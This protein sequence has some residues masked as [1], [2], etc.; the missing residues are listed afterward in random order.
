MAMAK[1]GELLGTNR[2]D[3]QLR[4]LLGIDSFQYLKT[5][6]LKELTGANFCDAC[7]SGKYPA[8]YMKKIK[9]SIF[10]NIQ[11]NSVHPAS[12]SIMF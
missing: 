7:L 12:A 5:E 9:A 3:E 6:D 2:T 1:Q 8:A 11:T 10:T 4:T